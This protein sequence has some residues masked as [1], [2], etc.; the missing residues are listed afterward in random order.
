[1]GA[2]GL[3]PCNQQSASGQPGIFLHVAGAP[4]P[5]TSTGQASPVTLTQTGPIEWD[6]A[7]YNTTAT[8]ITAGDSSLSNAWCLYVAQYYPADPSN[9]DV[10]FASVK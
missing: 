10:I 4:E 8:T 5:T 1:M 6:C 7:E 9:A 2:T 3:Y